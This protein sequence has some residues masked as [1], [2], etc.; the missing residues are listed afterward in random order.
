MQPSDIY[1]YIYIN[2]CFSSCLVLG[3]DDL[4]RI[5]A[6]DGE[7][8]DDDDEEDVESADQSIGEELIFQTAAKFVRFF[9]H[10]VDGHFF[11]FV[12]AGIEREIHVVPNV[13]FDSLLLSI[14]IPL[15]DDDLFHHVGI[16]HATEI[17]LV[18]TEETFTIHPSR[19]VTSEKPVLMHYPNENRPL[20]LIWKFNL[21]KVELPID[22][23]AKV[24]ISSLFKEQK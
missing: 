19:K 1:I 23:E 14:K 4:N 15:P 17:R 13:D 20:F 22:S 24:D 12:D 6:E 11:V 3:Q 21:A 8:L 2:I 9:T 18:P 10:E 5:A 7:D 16:L